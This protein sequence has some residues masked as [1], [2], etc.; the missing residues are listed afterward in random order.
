L[1]R[2]KQRIG[3]SDLLWKSR[4]HSRR[5]KRPLTAAISGKNSLHEMRNF[6]A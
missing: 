6:F 2:I 1:S 3:A 5:I 4:Q